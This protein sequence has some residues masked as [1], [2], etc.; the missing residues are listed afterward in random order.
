MIVQLGGMTCSQPIL[1]T[2]DNINYVTKPFLFD[3]SYLDILY[4]EAERPNSDP[5]SL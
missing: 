1:C 5:K 2:P 4:L 3:N